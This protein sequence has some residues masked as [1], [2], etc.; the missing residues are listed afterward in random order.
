MPFYESDCPPTAVCA[1]SPPWQSA[2]LTRRLKE[3]SNREWSFPL[4]DSRAPV[5]IRGG[6][7][8]IGC[9]G[10]GALHASGWM[11]V[12]RAGPAPLT[13]VSLDS[14]KHRCPPLQ[15]S[16]L[17]SGPAGVN[18]LRSDG[19]PQVTQF[20]FGLRHPH[21]SN[22]PV[23]PRRAGQVALPARWHYSYPADEVLTEEAAWHTTGRR[24]RNWCSR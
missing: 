8:T 5:R 13:L 17:T 15:C 11:K 21:F 1:P 24:R 7:L 16:E 4:V 2:T 20:A 10:C 6:G 18:K 9:R 22:E 3:P 23:P 12:L 19:L 14:A